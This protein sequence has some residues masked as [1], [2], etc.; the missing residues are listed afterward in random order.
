MRKLSTTFR[1]T[2]GPNRLPSKSLIPDNNNNKLAIATPSSSSSSALDPNYG[3]G[4]RR[5]RRSQSELRSRWSVYLIISSRLPKT[6]VGVTTNFARRLKQHNG[7]LRGGAKSSS[8]GR[9]WALAC[10][11]RG[12]K[13]RS[14]ACEFESKWKNTSR[15]MPRKEKKECPSNPLLQ[16]REEALNR[17]KTSFDCDYLKIEWK[18][19]I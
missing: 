12:F 15:K 2:K 18:S 4:R 19:I 5:R 14:E 11:I 9:P 10:I 17:V 1:S 7:E 6:Y 16:H 8:A 13:N 3:K